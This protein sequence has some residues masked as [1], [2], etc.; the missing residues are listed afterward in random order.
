[1]VDINPLPPEQNN[2]TPLTPEALQQPGPNPYD[3]ITNTNTVPTGPPKQRRILVVAGIFLVIMI[4]G[5]VL[6][7][8]LRNANSG[9][10]KELY[11]GV[12]KQ[13]N[14]IIF[15]S[16]IGEKNA[17]GS[18]ARNL[19]I[20]TRLSMA[21][22]KESV[23]AIAKKSGAPLDSKSIGSGKDPKIEA[24]LVDAD[25][26]NRF[27]EAFIEMIQ[28]MLQKHQQKLRE[29]YNKTSSS[30]DKQELRKTYNNIQQLIIDN[31]PKED[32]ETRQETQSEKL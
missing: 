14:Q 29:I 15:I 10:P 5:I 16:E 18:A 6:A 2:Q 26:N 23:T 3:F 31:T 9:G 25:Q 8:V 24:A 20:T 13:Q 1:M 17:Q 30:I 19:A 22:A 28:E 11:A 32:E 4:I 7:S 12:I 21:N 27:D